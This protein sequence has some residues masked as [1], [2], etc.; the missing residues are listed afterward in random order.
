MT[1]SR[2]APEFGEK[3]RVLKF[4][5]GRQQLYLRGTVQKQ[6]VDPSRDVNQES[7]YPYRVHAHTHEFVGTAYRY[8]WQGH[9]HPPQY[10][11]RETDPEKIRQLLKDH[12]Y[13]HGVHPKSDELPDEGQ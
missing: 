3:E 1:G 5:H 10:L 7:H 8:Q 9:F 11:G 6:A 2:D 12:Y 4:G 13:M